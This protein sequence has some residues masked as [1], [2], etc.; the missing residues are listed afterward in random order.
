MNALLRRGPARELDVLRREMDRLFDDF[1]PTPR[2]ASP[3]VWAPRADIVETNDAYLLSLDLPG[4][5][6]D[7]LDI[8]FEDGTLKVSG[9]RRATSEHQD[10]RFHRVERS[11]GRFFRS[12]TLGA[13]IES[14]AIEAE[15]GDGVLEL[16]V[17]K[18]ETAQPRQI[19]V[20]TRTRLAETAESH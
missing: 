6:R 8:T 17:P 18:A 15:F 3:T 9:E 1:V 11:Y 19:E 14:D 12:F 20:R 16:R 4:I 5:D 10:G 13:D 7:A 2:S